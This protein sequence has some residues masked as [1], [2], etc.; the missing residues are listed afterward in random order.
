[1]QLGSGRRGPPNILLAGLAFAAIAALM[2]GWYVPR[3]DARHAVPII[4]LQ[5]WHGSKTTL[6]L[7]ARYTPAARNGYLGFLALDCLFPVL[8]SWLVITVV[9]TALQ[10]FGRE[11]SQLRFALVFPV[12]AA[13]AD[14]LENFFHAWLT[15]SYPL[16]AEPL[17]RVAAAFTSLKFVFLSGNYLVFGVALVALAAKQLS[18]VRS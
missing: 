15:L 17:S 1:M 4:D 14:L 13:I 8:G 9:R 5:G 7:L 10:H 6:D 2:M 18:R 11:A 3:F 12:M 16:H